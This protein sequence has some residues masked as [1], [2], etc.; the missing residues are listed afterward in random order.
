[1]TQVAEKPN[2][3][4]GEIDTETYELGISPYE[5]V[6]SMLVALLV[7]VGATASGHLDDR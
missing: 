6:A 4:P 3:R 1:M 5:R 2:V 7:L